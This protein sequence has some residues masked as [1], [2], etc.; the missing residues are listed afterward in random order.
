MAELVLERAQRLVEQGRDVAILWT[1]L[2][3]L[4]EPITWLFRPVAGPFRAGLIPQRF[5]NL[6]V[7]GAARNIEEGAA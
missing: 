2:P 6:N 7:F 1:A 4:P 5:I 3:G